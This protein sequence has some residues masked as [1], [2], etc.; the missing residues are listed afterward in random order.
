MWKLDSSL[1]F[2]MTRTARSMKRA[3]DARLLDQNL[4]ATQYIVLARLWEED[5]I[6]LSELGE[7][8]YFDNPTLTGIVDR[9]E[10]DGLLQRQRDED[11]RRVVKVHLTAKGRTLYHDI[12]YLAEETDAE[13]WEG[14]TE[15]QKK[16]L[17]NYLER[18]WKKLYGRLD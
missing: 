17:L 4:T 13:S 15:S 12:G 7:R 1:G 10:R 2:L 11:D 9:M 3:L 5:G 14:F 18:I 16:E 6:S 8:L